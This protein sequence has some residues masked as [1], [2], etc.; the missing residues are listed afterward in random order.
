MLEYLSGSRVRSWLNVELPQTRMRR[1]DLLADLANGELFHLELQT[2]NDPNIGRRLLEY[3]LLI[4]DALRR[5]P[6]QMVLYVGWEPMRM[7]S[8][9]N[10][11]NLRFDYSMVDI[12]DLDPKDLAA[13]DRIEDRILSILFGHGDAKPAAISILHEI[14]LMKHP[15]RGDALAKLLVTSGLRQLQNDLHYE[16]AHMPLLSDILENP[17]LQDWFKQGEAQGKAEGKA[18]EAVRFTIHLLERRFGKLPDWATAQIR[19]TPTET[20]ENAID[21]ILDAPTLEA[22]L[23]FPPVQ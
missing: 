14:S 12:R 18:D 17:F 23:A 21:H 4:E 13:S 5:E 8:A 2:R 16:V 6:E 15:E 3:R 10:R 20:L 19:A 11:R 9:L 22:A 1:I 7:P